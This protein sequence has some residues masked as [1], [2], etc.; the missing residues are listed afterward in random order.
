M[1]MTSQ[2]ALCEIDLYLPA[3]HSLKAKRRQIKP[4]LARLPKEFNISVAEVDHHD[5][6]QT[7]TLAIATVSNSRVKNENLLQNVIAWIE[8]HFPDL[9][10]QDTRYEY[11]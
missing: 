11:L 9:Y 6:W 7:A 5:V 4:L 1:S 8:M 10:I 2:I 3:T